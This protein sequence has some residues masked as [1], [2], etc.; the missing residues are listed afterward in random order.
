MKDTLMDM[1]DLSDAKELLLMKPNFLITMFTICITMLL[2]MAVIWM[3][4]SKI[5]IYI[6]AAG[7]VR[8]NE[9]IS[10]LMVINGGKIQSIN[11]SEGQFVYKGDMLLSF[12]QQSLYIQREIINRDI[13]NLETDIEMLRLYRSSI[14]Q[15]ENHLM[16]VETDKGRAYSLKVQSFLWERETTLT[17]VAEN[18][19]DTELLKT[20]AELRLKNARDALDKLLEE[21]TWL[22]RY[23]SSVENG[24]DMISTEKG[25]SVYKSNY[26]SSYQNYKSGLDVLENEKTQAQNNLD[27]VIRLYDLGNVVRNEVDVAQKK[28]N[29]ATDRISSY[30]QAELA[31]TDNKNTMMDANIEE[32]RKAVGT[33]EQE[34]SLYSE[35]RISPLMQVEQARIQLLS[36]ID[37]EIQQNNDNISRLNAEI[38]SLDAKIKESQV[39]APIDGILNLNNELNEGDI[40][41]PGTEIGAITPPESDS[42]K[43]SLQVS[44]KDIASVKLNQPI[45]IKFLALPYQEYGMA[46]GYVSLISADSRFNAQTGESFYIVEA[47]LE[48]KPIKSYRGA[49]E[50]IRVGMAVEGRLISDQKSILQWLLEKMNFA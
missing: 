23:R 41:A 48:N 11:I 1:K 3:Q 13:D 16:N 40:I 42:F 8:T 15:L 34:V 7:M 50:N 30:R 18:N 33:A 4:V 29:D 26:A 39:I 31:N 17:Q 6:K 45:K 2:I 37:S 49:D 47:I 10:K 5:D 36:Q 20:S 35:T 19:K 32:A 9:A 25:G 43:V 24:R 28:L 12:D 22:K 38:Y 46:D 27:N 21:Q 44:N 14:D